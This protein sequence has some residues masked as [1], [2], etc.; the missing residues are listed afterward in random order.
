ME[1]KKEI[2]NVEK[3]SENEYVKKLV[4]DLK[5]SLG[6]KFTLTIN[7]ANKEKK[8]DTAFLS[9]TFIND[10]KNI[11]DDDN[12]HIINDSDNKVTYQVSIDKYGDIEFNKNK[13][14]SIDDGK[15]Y[16]IIADM[17]RYL[18]NKLDDEENKDIKNNNKIKTLNECLEAVKLKC[19]IDEDDVRKIIKDTIIPLFERNGFCVVLDET[20]EYDSKNCQMTHYTIYVEDRKG[21]VSIYLIEDE[22]LTYGVYDDI[23]SDRNRICDIQGL[24]EFVNN[25]IF[26]ES[27][28]KANEDG[29]EPVKKFRLDY[30]KF[31]ILFFLAYMEEQIGKEYDMRI[32]ADK[33]SSHHRLLVFKN[34]NTG[35][36]NFVRFEYYGNSFYTKN[37][38]LLSDCC[39]NSDDNYYK[40]R[41]AIIN[42]IKTEEQQQQIDQNINNVY[43]INN[44]SHSLNE[45]S[46]EED[47]EGLNEISEEEDS[48]ED[49]CFEDGLVL[50]D[51]YNFKDYLRQ[52]L[53][54][55]KNYFVYIPKDKDVQ[56]KYGYDRFRCRLLVFKNL[57]T[58][59]KNF[60]IVEHGTDSFYTK[61]GVFLSNGRE[62]GYKELFDKIIT[63]IKSKEQQQNNQNANNV[64]QINNG[65]NV[66]SNNDLSSKNNIFR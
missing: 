20:Q 19:R 36:K 52:E 45:M 60:V 30:N 21:N 27:D 3:A 50:F 1:S 6:E 16:K 41:D 14:N 34:K 22:G 24:K 31:N 47:S 33:N 38:V 28:S 65:S 23:S 26:L 64:H 51:V 55:D 42:Y 61:D 59:A 66:I 49:C 44:N 29:E 48:E 58:G 53:E 13:I 15:C 18:K 9:L 43:Q 12:N 56:N 57:N 62:K 7:N 5:S 37:G 54:K 25:I 4:E 8:I 40:L 11:N 2:V 35:V 39:D 32:I 17:K 46:E 63:Y 10:S